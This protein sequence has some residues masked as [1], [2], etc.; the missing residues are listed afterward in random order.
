MTAAHRQT[1][2]RFWAQLVRQQKNKTITESMTL[3]MGRT[4]NVQY[5]SSNFKIYNWRS[6]C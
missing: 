2:T 6:R 5:T 3:N 1:R 4:K